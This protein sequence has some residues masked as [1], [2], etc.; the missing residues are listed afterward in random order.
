MEL[1][2]EWLES[3]HFWLCECLNPLQTQ[4]TIICP[5]C[6]TKQTASRVLNP[7]VMSNLKTNSVLKR[8]GNF[9]IAPEIHKV[10]SGKAYKMLFNSG[11]AKMHGVYVER[12]VPILANDL[13]FIQPYTAIIYWFD[14]PFRTKGL[15]IKESKQRG[16]SNGTAIAHEIKLCNLEHKLY[17]NMCSHCGLVDD[18]SA[19]IYL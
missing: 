7:E 4:Y 12:R 1:K 17:G 13:T 9:L 18:L 15:Y 11:M 5:A 2:V 19:P 6:N 3:N 8:R 16:S 14:F 10:L